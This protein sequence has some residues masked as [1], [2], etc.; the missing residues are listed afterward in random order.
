[1]QD[2]VT[3]RINAMPVADAGFDRVVIPGETV[4]FDGRRSTDPDGSITRYHWDFRDGAAAEGDVVT[5]AF[6]KPGRYT[7]ELTVADD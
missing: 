4:T 1:A 6:D 3:I 2:T 7:V 5:H